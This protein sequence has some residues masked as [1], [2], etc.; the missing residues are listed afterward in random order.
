MGEK[1]IKRT[2][3]YVTWKSYEIQYWQNFIGA[4]PCLSTDIC[5][6]FSATMAKLSSYNRYCMVQTVQNVGL[7]LNYSKWKMFQLFYIMKSLMPKTN[8]EGH[9]YLWKWRKGRIPESQHCSCKQAYWPL[10]YASMSQ[11]YNLTLK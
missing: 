7:H 5:G 3:F 2:I 11:C 6:C 9:L 10:V 4:Y 1:K 8:L